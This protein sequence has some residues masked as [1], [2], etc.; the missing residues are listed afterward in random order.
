MLIDLLI[1][2]GDFA[3]DVLCGLFSGGGAKPRIDEMIK[4][5]SK[6]GAE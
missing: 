3:C 5:G 2:L 4:Q 1:L 6:K